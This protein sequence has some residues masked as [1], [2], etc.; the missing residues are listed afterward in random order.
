M[1]PLYIELTMHAS[2]LFFPDL[3]RLATDAVEDGEESGLERV[4]EHLSLLLSRRGNFTAARF[5][6]LANTPDVG[7]IRAC[8]IVA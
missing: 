7:C 2:Y 6:R 5:C 1:I 8:A 4:L 3:Q